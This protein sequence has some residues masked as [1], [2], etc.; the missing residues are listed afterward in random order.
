MRLASAHPRSKRPSYGFVKA[1]LAR[2]LAAMTLGRVVAGLLAVTVLG[3][4]VAVAQSQCW[5][6]RLR[7][8]VRLKTCPV[9]RMVPELNIE[10]RGLRRGTSGLVRLRAQAVFT[11]GWSTGVGREM[12][13]RGDAELALQT[14]SSTVALTPTDGWSRDA[15]GVLVGRVTLP[16]DLPDGR[17]RLVATVETPLG[18]TQAVLPLDVHAPARILVLTDRPLYEPGNLVQFRAVVLRARDQAP[19]DGRPGRWVVRDPGGLEILEER[20]AAGAY[21]VVAGDVPLDQSARTGTWTVEWRSGADVGRTTFRVEPFQLPRFSIE[22]APVRPHYGRRAIPVLRGTIRYASGAPVAAAAVTFD[23]RVDGQWPPPPQWLQGGL[24][25]QTV[26]D[27]QGRFELRLPAVPADLVGQA[28]LKA[29]IAATDATGDRE[30]GAATI[31][32]AKDDIAVSTVTELADGLVEGF[33]NRLYLR[34]TTSS[35]RVLRETKLHVRRAWDPTDPGETVE[36]DVDGVAALQID[37]GPA[38]TVVE[39]GVP[40]RPPLPLPPVR[41]QMLRDY[42]RDAGP[43]LADQMVFDRAPLA[44]CA[45]FVS[46]EPEVRSVLWVSARGRVDRVTVGE[47]ALAACVQ[48]RL[49]RLKFSPGASRLFELQHRFHWS[50]PTV[51]LSFTGPD[52]PPEPWRAQMEALSVQARTCL[53]AKVSAGVPSQLLAWSIDAAGRVDLRAIPEPRGTARQPASVTTCLVRRLMGGEAF[54]LGR[55]GDPV[56][57]ANGL[58]RMSLKPA[59]SQ[60]ADR[61]EDRTYLG[62]ELLVEAIAG[63]ERIGKTKVRLRPGRIP[64]LRLRPSQVVAEPGATVDIKVLRGPDFSGKLPKKLVMTHEGQRMTAD[65]DPQTRVARFTLPEGQSGWYAVKLQDARTAVFV[66]ERRNLTVDVTPNQPRYSPGAQA[67]L[68]V[69]TTA[70]GQPTPAMVGLF[71]VDQSLQQLAPL[72]GPEVWSQMLVLPQLSSSAFG[73]LD[74]VALVSGRVQ[75]A[76]ALAA[77]V[78]RVSQVPKREAIDRSVTAETSERFDPTI[79]LT[80]SFYGLLTRLMA[81]V[82]QWDAEAPR[83]AQMVPSVM[84][85]LWN[86]VVAKAPA[87]MREDPFGRTMRL[88]LLPDDLLALVDPR[89]VVTNGTRLPEDVDNWI[90]WVRRNTP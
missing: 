18:R 17:H 40:V 1:R 62:Y 29:T 81:R 23:W 34:A 35:G 76:A 82:R 75:G 10:V 71:G 68:A 16:A 26:A 44:S 3:I 56:A 86:E 39:P 87:G 90:R 14:G 88:N 31:L 80:D 60:R 67:V 2:T 58:V 11:T 30:S 50:G 36:T 28:T 79:P 37:P 78:L 13:R 64:P 49:E 27:A 48:G 5:S 66:P 61:K 83:E 47:G 42:L 22:A 77:T 6:A 51:S 54:R 9:G 69:R 41:R 45:R 32:L 63:D 21:G 52:S 65:F 73:A 89:V 55:D 59:P 15:E 25:K 72:P 8:G 57:P 70:L 4:G 74:A 20:T 85:E 12:L 19:L 38:V 84:A 43:T 7:Y 53:P 46:Q 33:N 24:P